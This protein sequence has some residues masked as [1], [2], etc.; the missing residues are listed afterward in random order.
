M[1]LRTA[2]ALQIA[3]ALCLSN[4]GVRPTPDDSLLE[5]IL[6]TGAAEGAPAGCS[7]E[8]VAQRIVQMFEAVNRGDPNV[9]EEFFGRESRGPFQWYSMDEFGRTEADKNH[10][11]AYTLDELDLYWLER[12]W[13]HERLQLRS[14]EFNGWEGARGLVHFGPIVLSRQADD[15]QPGLGGPE[16][17]AEGKGAY[18]CKTRAFVVL[19]LSMTMEG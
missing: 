15:L 18:H 3:F 2:I 9:V 12:Y 19:S 1:T 10:F 7:P 17:L 6:V 11:V 4:C 13:Q 14:V 8:E 16:R 5:N